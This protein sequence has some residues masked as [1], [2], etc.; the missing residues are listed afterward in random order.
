MLP[1][2]SHTRSRQ[3][4][5]E[6]P[7]VGD[8]ARKTVELGHHQRVITADGGEGLLKTRTLAVAAGH[9]VIGTDPI[10]ADA[11]TPER[12]ALSGEV[13]LVGR[14]PRISDRTPAPDARSSEGSAT[15]GRD[16]GTSSRRAGRDGRVDGG[17][18]TDQP[19]AC[20][21]PAT[22]TS[23]RL[24]TVAPA[25]EP[26]TGTRAAINTRNAANESTS[27]LISNTRAT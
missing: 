1:I 22:W 26:A 23:M 14:A 16:P 8:R 5:A 13:L 4:V 18:T 7:S 27:H 11:E 20:M 25:V 3:R 12:L 24:P 17:Y 15:A 19:P 10:V 2:E 6:R 21:T 9:A